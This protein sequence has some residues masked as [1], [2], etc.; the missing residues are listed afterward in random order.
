MQEGASTTIDLQRWCWSNIGA[1]LEFIFSTEY[2]ILDP[3]RGTPF[4]EVFSN[5]RYLA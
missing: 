1:T 2:I 4:S 3:R 5:D